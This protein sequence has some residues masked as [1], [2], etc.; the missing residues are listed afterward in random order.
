MTGTPKD[1][2]EG[3][4]V[5]MLERE[6]SRGGTTAKSGGQFWIPNNRLLHEHGQEQQLLCRDDAPRRAARDEHARPRL[7]LVRLSADRR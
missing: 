1:I 5:V 4:S 7:K 6:A 2:P 3:A